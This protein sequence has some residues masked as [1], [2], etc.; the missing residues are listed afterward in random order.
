VFWL[1]CADWFII[2]SNTYFCGLF[3]VIG[4]H[5]LQQLQ[6]SMVRR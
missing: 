4:L 1:L 3:I 6:W 5:I 2:I